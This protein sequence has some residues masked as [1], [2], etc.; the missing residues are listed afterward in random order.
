MRA[1]IVLAL[2]LQTMEIDSFSIGARRK[3]NVV[4]RISTGRPHFRSA[5]TDVIE[6]TKEII[7][8]DSV[9][10][11]AIICGGGPAGLLTAIMLAQK[12]PEVRGANGT[13]GSFDKMSTEIADLL[14]CVLC[15]EKS[16]GV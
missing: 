16:Q 14:L 12:F 15:T 9:A 5:P 13:S 8:R 11:D 3:S 6:L 7:P 2:L 10:T 1:L 4:G